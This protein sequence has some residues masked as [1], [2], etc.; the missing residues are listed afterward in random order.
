MQLKIERWKIQETINKQR[1]ENRVIPD[2]PKWDTIEF[3]YSSSGELL[4]LY[5]SEKRVPEH[6]IIDAVNT[7]R[8]YYYMQKKWLFIYL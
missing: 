5:K 3:V 7:E 8:L 6:N 2:Y 1:K 4:F